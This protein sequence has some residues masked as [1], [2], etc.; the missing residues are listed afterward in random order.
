MR[1]KIPPKA[2]LRLKKEVEADRERGLGI[3]PVYL[4]ILALREGF[5]FRSM[6]RALAPVV[7]TGTWD[8]LE[9][10]GLKVRPLF[11]EAKKYRI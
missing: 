9:D 6:I 2:V 10:R 5:A 4:A 11:E 3:S 1:Y 7:P 8:K